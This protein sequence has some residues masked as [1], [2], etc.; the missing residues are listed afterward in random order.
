MKNYQNQGIFIHRRCNIY[1]NNKN[2][3][4]SALKRKTKVETTEKNNKKIRLLYI[5]EIQALAV[6]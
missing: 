2:C 6:L 5:I 3:T 1:N 4:V